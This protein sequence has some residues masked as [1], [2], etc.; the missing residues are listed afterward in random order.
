MN[1][2]LPFYNEE[3][4]KLLQMMP[5][6][7]LFC[8]S[9]E[10]IM[11]NNT[12]LTTPVHLPDSEYTFLHEAAIIEYHGILFA[13]WYNCPVLELQGHTPIR[14]CRS[15]DGG[16]TWSEPEII[17]EA[18]GSDILYCPPVYGICDDKL[19]LLLN[20][21]VA[22]DHIHSLD[23]YILNQETDHFELLW[24]RPVP[25]KLNT[26]VYQLPNGKLM[27][28]GR[29]GE[30]DQF[31]NTPAVLISDNG[32]ID[33]EWR[34]V[35]IAENGYLPDGE[36]YVHPEISAVVLPDKIYMFC[37]NDR[38]SVP[39]LY[40]SEDNGE[41][42]S[43]PIAHNIPF[44]NS[45]IY[46]GT[47]SDG[48]HYVVGNIMKQDRSQLALYLTDL[49]DHSGQLCFS[50]ELIL[51]NGNDPMYPNSCRWHYPCAIEYDRELKII[52]TVQYHDQSRGAA[53]ISV[54]LI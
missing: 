53:L 12:V 6:Q 29:M 5:C 41:S 9:I 13:S 18:P 31:P 42:W 19:Y 52:C 37:R 27:L 16:K 4:I 38:R 40:I 25:F 50:E 14:G 3:D 43:G 17:A 26:N 45:K 35:K 44:I 48:R 1:K 22:P 2:I 54:P 21:M 32:R 20:Q 46:S 24:S 36:Q 51:R 33:T 11:M 28:P 34:M 10:S 7:N 49:S 47:L 15:A 23:L 30:L 39:I 8:E